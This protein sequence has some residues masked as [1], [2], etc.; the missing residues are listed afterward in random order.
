MTAPPVARISPEDLITL[1]LDTGTFRSWDRPL[2]RLA[3][4]DGYAEELA[5]AKAKSGRDESITTARG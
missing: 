3:I 2:P 4:E 1:T 5:A